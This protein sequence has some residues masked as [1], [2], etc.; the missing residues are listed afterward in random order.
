MMIRKQLG[1]CGLTVG[2]LAALGGFGPGC[3][4]PQSPSP[5]RPAPAAGGAK[6]YAD[7]R[8]QLAG[9]WAAF[10]A[11]R[12]EEAMALAD[13]CTSEYGPLAQILEAGLEK[14]GKPLPDGPV[15]DATKATID[16]NAALNDVATSHFLKG[17]C[18]EKLGHPAEAKAAYALALPYT[19]ARAWDPKGWFWR[20]AQAAAMRLKALTP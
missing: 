2:L 11:G 8:E 16:A 9:I 10:N 14:I 1:A 12:L 6:H 7:S 5:G 17:L 19:Y 15:D 18:A 3:A 13:H 20:P 4:A